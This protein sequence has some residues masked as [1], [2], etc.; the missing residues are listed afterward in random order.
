MRDARRRLNLIR[1]D[2]KG[3]RSQCRSQRCRPLISSIV[4]I[5]QGRSAAALPSPRGGCAPLHPAA[6]ALA[7]PS[8]DVAPTADTAPSNAGIRH[9]DTWREVLVIE[10]HPHPSP[11]HGNAYGWALPVN[12]GTKGAGRCMVTDFKSDLF[13]GT[14]MML[15]KNILPHPRSSD[16][17]TNVD[18]GRTGSYFRDKKRTFQGIVWGRFK[19]PGMPM[20]ESITGQASHCP[21]GR[22]PPWFIVR[23][24]LLIICGLTSQL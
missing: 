7:P 2:D 4:R 16:D 9:N 11:G 10:D 21:L 17:V 1:L 18:I 14:A 20:L 13:V 22:L 15:I 12:N 3:R 23:V 24:A 5:G 6:A 19:R 8:G